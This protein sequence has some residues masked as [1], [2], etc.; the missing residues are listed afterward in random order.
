MKYEIINPEEEL[1]ITR[2]FISE[3][4]ELTTDEKR[5]D[6]YDR[7]ASNCRIYMRGKV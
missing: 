7:N 4:F 3:A 1:T 2:N 6:M 5:K